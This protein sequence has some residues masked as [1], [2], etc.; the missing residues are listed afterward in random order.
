MGS[1]TFVIRASRV[2]T[3]LDF[4]GVVT[5]PTAGKCRHEAELSLVHRLRVSSVYRMQYLGSRFKDMAEITL[6]IQ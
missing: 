4:P 1:L 2:S 3:S 6:S 5:K